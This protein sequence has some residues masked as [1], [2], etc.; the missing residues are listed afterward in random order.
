MRGITQDGGGAGGGGGGGGV[1]RGGVV[2][3]GV[4]GGRSPRAYEFVG[5]IVEGERVLQGVVKGGGSRSSLSQISM[6]NRSILGLQV[7]PVAGDFFFP[8][9]SPTLSLVLYRSL[10]SFE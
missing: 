3:R 9:V 7:Q 8:L 6:G 4:R 10:F 2:Q 1:Q 5:G